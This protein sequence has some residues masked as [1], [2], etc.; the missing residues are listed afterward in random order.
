MHPAVC[1]LRLLLMHGTRGSRLLLHRCSPSG[2]RNSQ[3]A[4]HSTQAQLWHSWPQRRWLW[5][6][7]RGNRKAIH[8]A[9]RHRA[10]QP[11]GGEEEEENILVIADV[12]R[13]AVDWPATA[14]TC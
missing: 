7:S 10:A 8:R 13:A 1:T 11:A 2:C 12:T 9:S 3:A 4:P 5:G 14:A 6:G